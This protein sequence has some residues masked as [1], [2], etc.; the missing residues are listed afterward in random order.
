MQL[1]LTC[2]NQWR[3]YTGMCQTWVC[4]CSTCVGVYQTC[5]RYLRGDN[6][7]RNKKFQKTN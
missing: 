3:A 6:V 4:M 2:T 5:A 7:F 1:E